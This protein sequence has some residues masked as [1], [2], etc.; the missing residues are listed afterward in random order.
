[1]RVPPAGDGTSYARKMPTLGFDPTPGDVGLTT[2]LARRFD[3]MAGALRDLASQLGQLDFGTWQGQAGNAAKSLVLDDL[4]PALIDAAAITAQIS[5]GVSSWSGK[6]SGF[7][8]EADTLERRAGSAAA[9]LESIRSQHAAAQGHGKVLLEAG[10]EDAQASVQS[11][12]A[13]ADDLHGRYLAAGE[14][15]GKDASGEN[16][17]TFIRATED[18]NKV[19]GGSL[20]PFQLVAGDA[21]VNLFGHLADVMHDADIQYDMVVAIGP[22]AERLQA[23]KDL[24]DS[25]QDSAR[26][27][28]EQGLISNVI[29]KTALPQGIQ[30]FAAKDPDLFRGAAMLTSTLGILGDLGTEIS[31]EDKGALGDV[32]KSVAIVNGGVIAVDMTGGLDALAA[33]N[34][35]DWI[36]GVGEGVIVTTGAYLAG[37]WLYH[38]WTPAHDSMDAVADQPSNV[39]E[40]VKNGMLSALFFGKL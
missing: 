40:T 19:A 34:S 25:F 15:A 3:D 17:S 32:D 12:S 11:V 7:Q 39:L 2:G 16:T 28:T 14:A 35:L 6:L 38:H 10:L 29:D 33:A 9:D 30:E 27:V 4:L 20:T 24:A 26:E 13:A 18:F 22:R 36:P 1:M 23:L 31:P 8:S 37:D 21:W 5:G